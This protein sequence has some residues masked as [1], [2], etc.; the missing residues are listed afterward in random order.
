[1]ESSPEA[2][3]RSSYKYMEGFTKGEPEKI[4]TTIKEFVISIP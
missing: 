1:M 2:N 4:M 3:C